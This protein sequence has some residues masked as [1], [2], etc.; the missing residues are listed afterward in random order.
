MK[1]RVIRTFVGGSHNR[2]YEEGEILEMPEGA[3]WL[4]VG[5][6]VPVAVTGPEEKA[7]VKPAEKRKITTKDTKDTKFPVEKPK[8][9]GGGR[10]RKGGG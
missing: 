8:R 5:F 2:L 10:P 4:R 6:A 3:D 7:V 1:V 9:S